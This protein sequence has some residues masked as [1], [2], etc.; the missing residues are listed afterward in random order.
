MAE[1]EQ[2]RFV[3]WLDQ[4]W[5]GEITCTQDP[6][7]R[8][9]ISL[10]SL[11]HEGG[12]Y[13][14]ALGLPLH[15][16]DADHEGLEGAATATEI[17]ELYDCVLSRRADPNEVSRFGHYLFDALLG[18]D[19]WS[20]MEQ[21]T[22]A[23]GARVLELALCLPVGDQY[24][25]RLTW[26]LMRSNARFL[27]EQGPKLDVAITRLVDTK[28]PT[29]EQLDVP[30]RVLFVIGTGLTEEK[31]RP[32]AEL[33]SLLR[34]ARHGR[35]MRYRVLERA[36]PTQL[37]RAIRDFHPE[38]V[39][40]ICHGGI[41]GDPPR[42]F[43][44][45]ETDK[46][47][48]EPK[49]YAP[50][51][52][53]DLRDG[54]WRPTVV[55][56]SAC[57]SGGAAGM[58]RY[59]LAGVHQS[60]PLAGAL[61]KGGIPIVLGMAGRVADVTSR[62]FARELTGAVI[63][64]KPLV[65]ATA[66]ARR[67][68][69]A[70]GPDPEARIDWAL[71]AIFVGAKVRADYKLVDVEAS[72]EL[73]KDLEG[74]I[75]SYGLEPPPV[76]CG[77]DELLARFHALFERRDDDDEDD[78]DEPADKVI[79]LLVDRQEKGIGRTRLLRE[80][81]AQAFRDGHLPLLLTYEADRPH[82]LRQ[83][84]D[85]LFKAIAR[86]R[87]DVLAIGPAKVSQLGLLAR[88]DPDVG[89]LDPSIK[90]DLELSGGELSNSAVRW[91]I[92]ADLAT[93]LDDAGKRHPFFKTSEG[94]AVVLLDDVD[95]YGEL[96]G[97]LLAPDDGL[98]GSMG[99]G[100]SERPIPVVMTCSRHGNTDSIFKGIEERTTPV[101]WLDVRPLGPFRDDGEDMLACQA[102]LLNPPA[103]KSMPGVTDKAY[104]VN[105]E[106]DETVRSKYEFLFRQAL[107]GIPVRYEQR[108]LF[109]L[110]AAA[111]P[112]N[113]TVEADD[114]ARLENLLRTQ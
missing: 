43:L 26:E 42:V 51:L 86:L 90:A 80:M 18:H 47:N 24:L 14:P 25:Q 62:L 48:L 33:Y 85:K 12:G 87:N 82:D 45:L 67:V 7:W 103:P 13:F 74:W 110:A 93:L 97:N 98:L 91:A 9:D 92:Q 27:V 36:T 68:A 108:E 73:W 50:Q 5:K 16:P 77:R 44:C 60:A 52:L 55:V 78:R 94:Q 23:A 34:Q 81:A 2:L 71:P 69:F 75:R 58:P 89:G 28:V 64:G 53:A 113:Y 72:E 57:V 20:E 101:G 70:G 61:V 56:L 49:R 40:F 79:A 10:D 35:A 112:A 1:H 66:L 59:V 83:L 11:P 4:D 19:L 30:P 3:V 65:L 38:I 54:D 32:G 15:D 96:V 100:T 17:K 106:V 63:R 76:F 109:L 102:V 104:A 95:D 39:H 29:P 37:K 114:E 21:K 99:F 31:I 105:D 6:T 22:E 107:K 111:Q 88:R 84:V 41:D 46:R 8:R